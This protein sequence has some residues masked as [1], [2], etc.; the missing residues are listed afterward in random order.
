MM[1]RL[2]FRSAK[3][4]KLGSMQNFWYAYHQHTPKRAYTKIT[5]GTGNC[6]LSSVDWAFIAAMRSRNDIFLN[7]SLPSGTPQGS[8]KVGFEKVYGDLRRRR[9]SLTAMPQFHLRGRNAGL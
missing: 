9:P 1:K 8:S 2:M 5:V 3:K 7:S 6:A 4:G